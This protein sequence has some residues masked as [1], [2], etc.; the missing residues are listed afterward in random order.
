MHAP[1]HSESQAVIPVAYV[2]RGRGAGWREQGGKG[3]DVAPCSGICTLGGVLARGGRTGALT[4]ETPGCL[5]RCSPD[6]V[7]ISSKIPPGQASSRQKPTRF[8]G[9]DGGLALGGVCQG[10]GPVG[11]LLPARAA[12]GVLCFFG[13]C[14]SSAGRAMK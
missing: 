1:P 10:L 11:F 9:G 4:S 7:S 5:E 3:G 14:S 2:G 6:A 8:R 12:E 13:P